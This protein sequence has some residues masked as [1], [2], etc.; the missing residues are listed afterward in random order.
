MIIKEIKGDII[1]EFKNGT[2]DIIVHGCNCFHIM[3]AG[4]AGQIASKIP[5]AFEADKVTPC[6]DIHKLG[7]FSIAH[8]SKKQL[9]INAYTQFH[10]GKNF[11]YAAFV[12]FLRK[13]KAKYNDSGLIVG[14]PKIGCG[15]GGGDWGYVKTLIEK[16][17]PNMKIIIVEYDSGTKTMGQAEID[18]ESSSS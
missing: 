6:G 7:S 13:F 14:F 16:H 5:L 18:F 3:G 8:I 2:I 10:I 11:E 15:I 12:Q 1:E 4:L 17:L 9:V